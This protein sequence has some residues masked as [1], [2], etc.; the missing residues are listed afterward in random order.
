M[1]QFILQNQTVKNNLITLEGK[2][3]RYLRQVLRVKTGDMLNVRTQYGILYNTTVSQI[4]DKSHI[5]ILQICGEKYSEDTANTKPSNQTEFFLFQ[6]I[7]RPQKFE[8][9]IRQATE[10][11]IKEIIPVL[12]EYTEKSSASIL[13]EKK[14]ERLE[15]IIKEARQQSG[16][17]VQTKVTPPATLK[18]ACDLWNKNIT[19]HTAEQENQTSLALVLSE[20][21][22]CETSLLKIIQ[23]ATQNNQ[24]ITKVALAVGSEGGISPKE[25]EILQ[26][27]GFFPVH[28][29]VNILRCETAALYGIAAVQSM[30]LL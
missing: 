2:D 29:N 6:F 15:K 20:R 3:F 14:K 16:S 18:E 23:N 9:I 21:T 13:E 19:N 12:G 5:I 8:Q 17:P 4:D 28:F 25:I 11:G 26:E 22:G 10:C 27:N 7:P 30:I 1:R 24:K